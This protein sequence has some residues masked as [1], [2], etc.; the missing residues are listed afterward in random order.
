MRIVKYSALEGLLKGHDVT[1]GS[2]MLQDIYK[3]CNF[4]HGLPET[5]IPVETFDAVLKWMAQKFYPNE[6]PN[7]ALFN[8][9]AKLFEGYRK[10]I[11]GRI[12]L[13]TMNALGPDQLAMRAPK[14]VGVNTNFGERTVEKVGPNNYLVK[15]KGVPLPGD[16]YSGIFAAGLKVQGLNPDVTW[17]QVGPEDMEFYVRWS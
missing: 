16:Y 11:L 14:L 8:V 2:P 3:L 10:T 9:G 1:D 7:K 17:K 13:A 12:Q 15:F 5:E 6:P 4:K